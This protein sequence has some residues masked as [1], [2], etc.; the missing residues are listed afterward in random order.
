MAIFYV[1]T[2][3]PSVIWD[4]ITVIAGREYTL[5]F[6][7]NARAMAWYLD[8]GDQ[9]GLPIVSGVRLVCGIPLAREVVGDS[10]MW[11]GT[12]MCVSTTQDGTDPGISDLGTRVVLIYDDGAAIV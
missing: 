7:W 1:D 6:R 5:G 9:D 3:Y 2:N 11:P 12:L 8:I 4:Q 10:R